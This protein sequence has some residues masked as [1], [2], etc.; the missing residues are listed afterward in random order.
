MHAANCDRLRILRYLREHPSVASAVAIG[1]YHILNGAPMEVALRGV[2]ALGDMP[3]EWAAVL[4]DQTV[5]NHELPS[6]VRERALFVIRRLLLR[7]IEHGYQQLSS[8][9]VNAAV[10]A[11]RQMLY[12]PKSSA[13]LDERVQEL[14]CHVIVAVT[15]NHF[16][17]LLLDP[18]MAGTPRVDCRLPDADVGAAGAPS[19]A[20]PD[21]FLE[22][23]QMISIVGKSAGVDPPGHVGVDRG[24][25]AQPI[26]DLSRGCR[27]STPPCPHAYE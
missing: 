16:V 14:A 13:L 5:I 11:I 2:K 19:T 7:A 1:H 18:D 26:Q 25:G 23:A 12:D 8:G 17:P 9:H 21:H 4:L 22:H 20:I 3:C 27:G 24:T 6:K 15:D 10:T